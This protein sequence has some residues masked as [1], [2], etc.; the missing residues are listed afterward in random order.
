MNGG[1]LEMISTSSNLIQFS[2]TF[3]RAITADMVVV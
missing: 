3:S 1:G 2:R